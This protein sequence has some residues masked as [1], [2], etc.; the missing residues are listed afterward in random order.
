MINQTNNKMKNELLQ[1]EES[2]SKKKHK[3]LLMNVLWEKL[4]GQEK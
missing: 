3:K 1:E 2:V 4:A